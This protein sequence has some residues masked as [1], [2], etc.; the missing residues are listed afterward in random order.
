MYYRKHY[1]NYEKANKKPNKKKFGN[2]HKKPRYYRI[3]ET[4]YIQHYERINKIMGFKNF[5]NENN[6][7][8]TFDIDIS[9]MHFVTLRELYDANG[10]N[11]IYRING[12]YMNKKSKFGEHGVLICCEV[13][14]VDLPS[15]LNNSIYAMLADKET[16][17]DIKGGMA[18]FTIQHY[19]DKK[20]NKECYS[21]NWEVLEPNT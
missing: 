11:A 20:Y 21:V 16:I 18:G 4:D 7:T 6:Y 14:L 13:G 3:N 19:I 17:E 5:A 2:E 10:E 8:L 12:A 15:H 9:N 1:K